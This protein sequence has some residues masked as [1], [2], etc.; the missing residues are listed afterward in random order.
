MA[1]SLV[2]GTGFPS[3]LL[4]C[5]EFT[6]SNLANG[7]VRDQA[8][9]GPAVIAGAPKW[10]AGQAFEALVFDRPAPAVISSDL[11]TATLPVRCMTVEAWVSVGRP[12]ECGGMVGV[13]PAKGKLEQ[14]WFLGYR[15]NRFCFAIADQLVNKM[16]EVSA[17]TAFEPNRWYH[18]AGTFDGEQKKIYVNGQLENM[19]KHGRYD[20]GYPQDGVY[21]I[22]L[23]REYGK[24]KVLDGM[25]REVRVYDRA[26]SQGEIRRQI[27][28]Q[29]LPV[30]MIVTGPYLQ[31]G[32]QTTQVIMWETSEP[33]TALVEYGENTQSMRRVEDKTVATIHEIQLSN[34]KPQTQYFYRVISPTAKGIQ[35]SAVCTFQTAVKDDAAFAFVV[36]GDSFTWVADAERPRIFDLAWR[37]RP[38]LVMHVGDVVPGGKFGKDLWP[39]EWLLPA[40][41][42]MSHVPLYVA[43]GNHEENADWFYQYVSYPRPENFY[44]FDYGNA[45]FA[46]LDS[47]QA[48]GFLPGGKQYE[49]LA[50][51]LGQSKAQWKFVFLHHPPYSSDDDDYGDT[52]RKTASVCGEASPRQLVPLFERYNVDIVWSGHIHLYERT[53]PLR[54]GKI[55]RKNGVTYVTTG[56]GGSDLEDFSPVRNWFAA[57]LHRNW[58]YCLVTIH[59]ESLRLT[60]LDIGGNL[61]DVY[62][63]NRPQ[64]SSDAREQLP[65]AGSACQAWGSSGIPRHGLSGDGGAGVPCRGGGSGGGNGQLGSAAAAP[66]RGPQG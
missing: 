30:P 41:E 3:G 42:L 15:N 36:M 47:N 32:T 12:A 34:L 19:S 52:W 2:H 59:G 16:F 63:L 20:I 8:H 38:N 44:S 18:V 53:W 1:S 24:D 14:G 28:Q 60:A 13:F 50:K 55:D 61:F 62:D 31:Q 27:F 54:A 22:G 9:T 5:W 40:G 57:K 46:V 21:A 10:A 45:H 23:Y 7:A 65:D 17:E 39:R 26:L 43:I 56:G 11:S 35:A 25:I 64:S 51:D 66:P 29:H 6:P 48:R 49:W 58:H 37:E 4:G 33:G